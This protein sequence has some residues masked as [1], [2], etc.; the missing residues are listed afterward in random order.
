M[1]KHWYI[2]SR[3]ETLILTKDEQAKGHFDG[4]RIQERKPI[5]FPQ[6]RGKLRPYGN[7]FYWA[8]AWA[9]ED[10]MIGEHPHQG[11]EIMSFVLTGEIEHY[12]SQL[13]GWKKL[14]AGDVQII[15]AGKGISHA[16][17][18]GAGGSIFQIWFD[19]G[20]ER[21]L[22]N[23]ATYDDYPADTFSVETIGGNEVTN[24]SDSIRMDAKPVAISRSKYADGL[25][26]VQLG[27]GKIHSCFILDG[28]VNIDG[29]TLEKGDFYRVLDGVD[30]TI[31]TENADV[32]IIENQFQ[33]AYKSYYEMVGAR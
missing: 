6:D 13:K 30:Y 25:H 12:D 28:T 20:L 3:M 19:P 22:S 2:C 26:S 17:K 21:T 7:L 9:T 1:F 14:K 10:S 23:P 27:A 31:E 15:R 18:V 24:Y 16:E 29:R 4:G 8:H 33:L 11:F 5:G 32:F